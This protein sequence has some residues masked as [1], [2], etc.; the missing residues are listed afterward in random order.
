MASAEQLR[1]AHSVEERVISVDRKLDDTTRSSSLIAHNFIPDAQVSSQG[2]CSATTSYGGFRLRI[3]QSI[4]TLHPRPITMVPLSG[5][6]KAV[7]STNGSP[8]VRFCGFTENVRFSQFPLCDAN[9]NHLDFVAGSGK[10]ILWLVLPPSSPRSALT[11]S[12]FELSSSIIQDILTLNDSGMASI[13]YFYFDFRDVDKQKLQNLLPSLLIQLSA[14]SDP[15]CDTLSHLYSSH[16][17]G[18]RKPNNRAMI[19]CLKE[20]L[21]L[22]EQFPTY[23]ILDAIDEC[24]LR[25][26]AGSPRE[27]VVDFIN[28]LVGLHLPNVHVCVTSRPEVDIEAIIGPLAPQPVSLH[29]QSGQKQDIADYVRSFVETD[30]RMRRWRDED[31]D[32]V[33]KTLPEKADGMYVYLHMTIIDSY[34]MD[35]VSLG[36]VP[37]G[38]T[39]GLFPIECAAYH[40]GVA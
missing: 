11:D 30:R 15:C 9:P 18:V 7:F 24:P 13:A 27:E 4:I 31:R 23:I 1:I 32:L 28:E 33:I 5:S 17:R 2:T 10:S 39:T 25:S 35:Q 16:D 6:F 8:L 12:H 40:G 29:N 3:H 19:E 26:S 20:M 22:N 36:I 34:Q 37:I 38:S 14:R 21:T